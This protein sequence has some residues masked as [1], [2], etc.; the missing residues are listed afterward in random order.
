MG[1]DGPLVAIERVTDFVV[2][3]IGCPET[4][5]ATKT[6]AKIRIPTENLR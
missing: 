5:R 6:A 1:I 4:T 2:F 3:I